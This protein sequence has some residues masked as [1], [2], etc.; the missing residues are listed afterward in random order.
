MSILYNNINTIVIDDCII[1]N[2]LMFKLLKQ[3]GKIDNILMANDGLDAINK[4][5]NNIE[6]ID[7]VFIDNQMPKI[8][9]TTVTKLLREINFNKIIIGITDCPED[10][11]LEFNNSGIDYIFKKPFDKHSKEI[12]FNF[13]DKNDLHKYPDKKLTLINLKL[14]WI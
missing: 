8:N 5:I 1:N 10:E 12:L 6:K 2:K 3:Y 13:L 4:I 11:L 9:G 7:I 14:E